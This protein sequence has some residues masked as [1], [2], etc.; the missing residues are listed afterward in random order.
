MGHQE[1]ETGAR[2]T[3]E[4]KVRKATKKLVMLSTQVGTTRSTPVSC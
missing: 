3:K 4:T 1:E 2:V